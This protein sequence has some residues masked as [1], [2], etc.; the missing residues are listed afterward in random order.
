MKQKIVIDL[1]AGAGGESCG[2]H[3]AFNAKDENI[4]L[5][6]VNHWE[7]ACNT[8]AANFPSDECLCQS[9]QTVIPTNLVKPGE[10]AELLWA[11]PECTHFST[12]RGEN[13]VIDYS[14]CIVEVPDAF[15][16][17]V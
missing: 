12:A 1:F 8:H 17:L 7:V 4:K 5:F 10:S 6:A 14:R 16:Q 13:G 3:S 11:S 9:I 15:E 2:I